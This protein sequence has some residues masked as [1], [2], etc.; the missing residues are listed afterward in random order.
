MELKRN[1]DP[2]TLYDNI[3]A[4]YRQAEGWIRCTYAELFTD[5]G[6]KIF[7]LQ[8]NRMDVDEIICTATYTVA[9]YGQLV[10]VVVNDR[11][12]SILASAFAYPK[13]ITPVV[14]YVKNH[15]KDGVFYVKPNAI[16]WRPVPGTEIP[17]VTDDSVKVDNTATKIA[18]GIAALSFLTR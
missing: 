2:N 17:P 3:F 11:V 4:K 5:Q 7:S 18:L 12:K 8:Y 15:I 10:P 9:D 16:R 13:E 14:E 6:Q 1:T